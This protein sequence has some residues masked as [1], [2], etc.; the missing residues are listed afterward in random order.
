MNWDKI[1]VQDNGCWLWTGALK[2]DGY[3]L[4]RHNGKVRLVHRIVWE[5]L[6]GPIQETL[7]HV[8]DKCSSKACCNPEHLEDVTA[9]ENILRARTNRD[10]CPRNHEYDSTYTRKNGRTERVCTTC[11]TLRRQKVA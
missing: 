3:G 9:R 7:D 5:E 4:S 8:K 6:V 1:V 2:Q 11:R 10:R